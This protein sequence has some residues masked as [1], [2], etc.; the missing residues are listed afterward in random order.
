MSEIKTQTLL[1]YIKHNA[2][3]SICGFVENGPLLN[4]I[5]QQTNKLNQVFYKSI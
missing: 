1:P 4:I 5:N 3:D 2:N